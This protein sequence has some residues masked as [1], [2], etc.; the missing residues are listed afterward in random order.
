MRISTSKSEAMVLSRKPVDCLLRVGNESLPQVKEFKY[1][2]VLFMSEGM[3]GCKT[4][5]RVGAVGVVLHA[6]CRK[7]VMK[8]ELSQKAKLS[9]YW[10]VFVHT[11]TYGHELWVMTE[12]MRS[13]VQAAKISFLHMMGGVSL[14]D[15]VRSSAIQEGLGVEP[16]LLCV[17]S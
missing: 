4:D 7:V 3:M 15:R 5:Q 11:L 17:E 12:R 1:L 13:Q 16:L 14:R 8:R 6:L 2:R 9:I 10:S